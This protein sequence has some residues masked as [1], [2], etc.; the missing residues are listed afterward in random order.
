MWLSHEN[1]YFTPFRPLSGWVQVGFPLK[2]VEC[3]T[4]NHPGNRAILGQKKTTQEAC[5]DWEELETSFAIISLHCGGWVWVL[6]SVGRSKST[7]FV[8]R[9]S[10]HCFFLGLHE[11]A[12]W[13]VSQEYLSDTG[14]WEEEAEVWQYSILMRA[15]PLTQHCQ[16]PIQ[17]LTPSFSLLTAPWVFQVL[18]GHVGEA[19]PLLRPGCGGLWLV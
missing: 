7:S 14:D 12:A 8:G 19:R 10:C 11:T 4:V 17:L 18:R 2:G 1:P 16:W 13:G 3:L 5:P 9:W 6:G 15:Q